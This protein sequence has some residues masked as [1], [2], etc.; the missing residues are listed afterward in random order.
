VKIAWPSETC[1]CAGSASSQKVEPSLSGLVELGARLAGSPLEETACLATMLL[2]GWGGGRWRSSLNNDGSPLQVSVSLSGSGARPAVRL[3]ADPAAEAADGE[4]RW[5]RA[6][7]A[8]SAVLASYAP[9]LKPLCDSVIERNLP[10]EPA[11]RAAL[12]SGAVWLAADLTGEGMAL[13]A[14]AKWGGG[15]QRW[16]RTRRWL[17]EILPTSST[18]H[19]IL[20]RLATRAVLISVGIEGATPN[21]ARAKL[22][23]RLD[24]TAALRDLDIPLFESAAISEFLSEVIED[25]RIPRAG[26]V[27]SIGFRAASGSISDVK[28][29]VCGH[30]VRRTPADWM[31]A[32]D[33]SIARFGLAPLPVECPTL[34][35]T[36]EL[37]FIGLGLDAERT[38]RLNIYLKRTCL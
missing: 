23:W 4:Q 2:A 37:A 6:G 14:T 29:D 22:Y 11:F 36:A 8:L 31:Q 27:G 19:E 3:I 12:P 30:C 15:S 20:D 32:I 5:H 18:A 7:G 24:G 34:L 35:E 16:M 9:D 21:N 26:I 33:R 25:R 28:L 1:S 17:D 10:A 13:Y 38:S